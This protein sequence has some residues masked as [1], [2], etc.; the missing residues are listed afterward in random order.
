MPVDASAGPPLP[1]PVATVVT[2]IVAGPAVAS[3]KRTVASVAETA[4]TYG[5]LSALW[6]ACAGL[7]A[8]LTAT[9]ARKHPVKTAGE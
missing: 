8:A 1:R 5:P 4:V 3:S 2:S 7:P 6:A 9:I